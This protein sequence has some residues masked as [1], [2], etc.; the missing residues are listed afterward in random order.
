MDD[1]TDYS[2]TFHN[3]TKK[4]AEQF[5]QWYSG[6]GEQDIGIWFDARDLPVPYAGKIHLD[7]A[8]KQVHV[9]TKSS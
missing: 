1:N 4:Q 9:A 8:T 7:E 5:A 2:V 3:L 6:Q